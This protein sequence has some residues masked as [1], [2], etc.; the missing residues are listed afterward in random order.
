VCQERNQ[1][2]FWDGWNFHAGPVSCVG[3]P[4]R[5]PSLIWRQAMRAMRLPYNYFVT[6]LPAAA[7]PGFC[8]FRSASMKM[9]S[10]GGAAQINRV[11]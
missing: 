1:R 5:L 9:K 7:L 10:S 3:R 6:T 2:I 11:P 8:V 4:L